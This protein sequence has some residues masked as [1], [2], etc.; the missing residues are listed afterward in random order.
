VVLALRVAHRSTI[1]RNLWPADGS[2]N[3]YDRPSS[4]SSTP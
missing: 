4:R 1:Y 3:H 2:S